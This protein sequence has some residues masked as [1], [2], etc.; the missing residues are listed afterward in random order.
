MDIAK[1]QVSEPIYWTHERNAEQRGGV[2]ER[3]RMKRGGKKDK[4]QV[5]PALWQEV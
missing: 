3:E 2:G 4:S 1:K 5:L